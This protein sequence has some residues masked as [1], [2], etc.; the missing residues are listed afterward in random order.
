MGKGKRAK[1]ECVKQ[2][3]ATFIESRVEPVDIKPI[4]GVSKTCALFTLLALLKVTVGVEDHLQG[5]GVSSNLIKALV[6][7]VNSQEERS[8]SLTNFADS[9]QSFAMC[10]LEEH[11]KALLSMVGFLVVVQPQ[12][13]PRTTAMC[14]LAFVEGDKVNTLLLSTVAFLIAIINGKIDSLAENVYEVVSRFSYQLQLDHPHRCAAY[15]AQM[16]RLMLFGASNLKEDHDTLIQPLPELLGPLYDYL[17]QMKLA[18]QA[19]L[20]APAM[21]TGSVILLS[22]L[23]NI[24]NQYRHILPR[25]TTMNI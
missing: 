1:V 12:L 11:E 6:N 3:F 16:L 7:E 23:E 14:Y 21:A 22:H 9:I 13:A 2:C 15:I 18:L 20:N 24:A 5:E 17:K 19:E 25:R 4:R 8:L 10:P